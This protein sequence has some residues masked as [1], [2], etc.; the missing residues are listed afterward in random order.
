MLISQ[1]SAETSSI[2]HSFKP[3]KRIHFKFNQLA[4]KCLS[5]SF[6]LF[7]LLDKSPSFNTS[8]HHPGP[9]TNLQ[10]Y[11]SQPS[12]HR[13]LMSQQ[14]PP[15]PPPFQFPSLYQDTAP[16]APQGPNTYSQS[17]G[18]GPPGWLPGQPMNTA[19]KYIHS[20]QLNISLPCE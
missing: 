13:S 10:S 6:S 20:L 12:T 14:Y 17:T 8:A 9:S 3:F 5:R 7:L 4:E 19:G 11:S 18:S 2:I 15:N 16:Y 1:S